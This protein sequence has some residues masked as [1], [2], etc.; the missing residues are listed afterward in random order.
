[1]SS[2]PTQGTQTNGIPYAVIP[3]LAIIGASAFVMICYVLYKHRHG[4]TEEIRPFSPEQEIYMREV[5][6]RNR[7]DIEALTGYGRARRG[8]RGW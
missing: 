3:L 5:R 4:I 7:E 1:M 2:T 8:S 6:Q